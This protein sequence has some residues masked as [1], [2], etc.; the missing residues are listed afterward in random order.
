V[1]D[2]L[3]HAVVGHNRRRLYPPITQYIVRDSR[4]FDGWRYLYYPFTGTEMSIHAEINKLLGA[5]RIL[6]D[7]HSPKRQHQELVISAE[8]YAYRR[9]LHWLS[10]E[11]V[12]A[13]WE[14]DHAREASKT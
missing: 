2:L 11:L 7:S 10:A 14:K 13:K 3:S 5:T 12:V 6:T 9:R 1:P 4:R 8:C